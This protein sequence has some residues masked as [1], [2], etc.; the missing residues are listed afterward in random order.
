MFRYIRWGEYETTVLSSEKHGAPSEAPQPEPTDLRRSARIAANT[1]LQ[2]FYGESNSSDD[3][4]ENS[5]S[6]N[7]SAIRQHINQTKHKMDWENTLVLDSDI[8]PYRLLVKES[9]AISELSPSLNL[10]TR[11]V[12]LIIFP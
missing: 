2:I 6:S 10:T 8:H 7:E 3:E 9:L 12:P 11:S 1:K 4:Q 5:S